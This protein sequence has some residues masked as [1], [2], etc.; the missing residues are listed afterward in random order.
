MIL[1]RCVCVAVEGL[2]QAKEKTYQVICEV[3]SLLPT[4]THNAKKK[5]RLVFALH[6][7]VADKCGETSLLC[8]FFP[9]YEHGYW[10]VQTGERTSHLWLFGANAMCELCFRGYELHVNTFIIQ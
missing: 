3:K 7:T 2:I 9:C 8:L 5:E 1:R 10:L 6:L 4:S